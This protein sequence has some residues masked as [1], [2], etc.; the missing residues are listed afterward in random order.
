MRKIR[1]LWFPLVVGLL[2]V[3]PWILFHLRPKRPLSVVV[4]DKTV[5][6]DTYLEHAGLFW[7]MDQLKIVQPSGDR[8][9]RAT[10]YF[11]ATPGPH[12][13]DPPAETRDLTD[14]AVRWKTHL[15]G[16]ETRS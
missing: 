15:H 9:D 11:G 4:L 14:D 6:F 3:L 12:P 8:Y 2:L 10:D 5:P 16:P 1:W 7:L 13:G